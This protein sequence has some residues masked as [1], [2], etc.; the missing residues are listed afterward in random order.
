MERK[1]SMD[2]E[3]ILSG[4]TKAVAK[5]MREIED[6]VPTASEELAKIEAAIEP[7]MDEWIAEREAKGLPAQEMWDALLELVERTE[8]VKRAD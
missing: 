1:D 7:L 8:L 3:R 6:E 2:L 5:L 4:E